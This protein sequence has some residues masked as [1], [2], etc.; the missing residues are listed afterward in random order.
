[1]NYQSDD[2]HKMK[3]P[4]DNKHVNTLDQIP[5]RVGEVEDDVGPGHAH[6]AVFGE[7]SED[8]PNYRNVSAPYE[9]FYDLKTIRVV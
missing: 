5:S 4:V 3:D 1:M 2:S 6:D 8:G 9:H 7:I